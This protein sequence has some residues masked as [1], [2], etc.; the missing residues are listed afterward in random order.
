M[1][2]AGRPGAAKYGAFMKK[3]GTL[4]GVSKEVFSKDVWG[5]SAAGGL[6]TVTTAAGKALLMMAFKM[7][8][9]HL[10]SSEAR[11]SGS[12]YLSFNSCYSI[13]G[14]QTLGRELLVYALYR[15]TVTPTSRPTLPLPPATSITLEGISNLYIFDDGM[16]VSSLILKPETTRPV[17]NIRQY[18]SALLRQFQQDT[19]LLD[20]LLR[21]ICGMTTGCLKSEHEDKY[22]E[23]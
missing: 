22:E 8:S 20:L 18:S 16:N 9:T 21:I 10:S 15:L 1:Y 17:R 12:R 11:I 6:A 13:L 7:D 2:N 19:A 5:A 4:G 14:T 23:I 3:G